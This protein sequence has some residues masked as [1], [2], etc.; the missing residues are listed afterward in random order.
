[1]FSVFKYVE[2]HDVHCFDTAKVDNASGSFT[3]I[4]RHANLKYPIHFQCLLG[5]EE[6]YKLNLGM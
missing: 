4:L 3:G 1:M 6:K 5:D 2:I